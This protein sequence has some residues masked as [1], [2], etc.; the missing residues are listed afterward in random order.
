MSRE[1]D[2]QV[3]DHIISRPDLNRC[4]RCGGP[5]KETIE[6]GCVAGHCSLGPLPE[7][8]DTAS[9][10]YSTDISAAWQVLE[11]LRPVDI[12]LIYYANQDAWQCNIGNGP[13]TRNY[14]MPQDEWQHTAPLAICL[15]AL[16]AVGLESSKEQ[17]Q[18]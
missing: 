8:A 15:A 9:A 17:D 11:A 6:D 7:R 1:I 10:P 16:K 18:E 4:E 3:R 2:I 5:L 13:L 14:R 12:D